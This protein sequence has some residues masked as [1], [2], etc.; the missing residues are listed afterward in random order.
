[1]LP[2]IGKSKDGTYFIFAH[3]GESTGVDKSGQTYTFLIHDLREPN[4]R[5]IS[6]A[7]FE[8][9]WSRELILVSRCESLGENLQKKF[10]I[11]LVHP[12][13]DQVPQAV[14]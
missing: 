13:S 8:A 9:I 5:S 10:D 1:M 3:I 4:L 6:Q 11:F 12:I 2:A 7:E 14:Y